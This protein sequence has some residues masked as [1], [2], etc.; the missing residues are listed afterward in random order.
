MRKSPLQIGAL[1]L[2][3]PAEPL[4]LHLNSRELFT[5]V[6]GFSRRFHRI[7]LRCCCS[8]WH[9]RDWLDSLN[10]RDLLGSFHWRWL[11]P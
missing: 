9:F 2:A 6:I 1:F 5:P 7:R 10:E 11:L 3:V 4:Q 8:H